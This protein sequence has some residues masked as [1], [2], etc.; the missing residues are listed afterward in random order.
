MY[1]DETE[2]KFIFSTGREFYCNQGIIGIAEDLDIS[3]GYDGGIHW[4]HWAQEERQ[5]LRDYVVALW[6]KWVKE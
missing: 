4:E 3:E 2:A 6:D 1:Y 5:E